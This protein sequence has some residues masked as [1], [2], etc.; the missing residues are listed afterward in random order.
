MT[1]VVIGGVDTTETAELGEVVLSA[2]F[3]P[4]YALGT[5][6][7]ARLGAKNG[8]SLGITAAAVAIRFRGELLRAISGLQSWIKIK[9]LR[10]YGSPANQVQINVT[11]T[12]PPTS[13]D[14]FYEPDLAP[15][16]NDANFGEPSILRVDAGNVSE[17]E[18]RAIG[19][20]L[21]RRM[22]LWQRRKT[23]T[24]EDFDSVPQLGKTLTMPDG[25]TGV[26]WECDYQSDAGGKESL[27]LALV[28]LS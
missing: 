22:L 10:I 16:V 24:V 20:Q 15:I 1:A 17:V 13:S 11:D 9:E 7:G 26:C 4:G 21:L 3:D 23:Y 8:L 5:G 6:S 19:R 28:D 27:R 12:Y 14:E 18:A 2:G 25:F